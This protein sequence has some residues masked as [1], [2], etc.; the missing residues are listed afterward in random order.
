LNLRC[1]RF[2]HG[3]GHVAAPLLLYL[4]EEETFW[5]LQLLYRRSIRY[6]GSEPEAGLLR[7]VPG[8]DLTSMRMRVFQFERLMATHLPTVC[9]Y[10]PTYLPTSTYSP[11]EPSHLSSQQQHSSN[12]NDWNRYTHG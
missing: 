4:G 3:I 7:Q 10:L 9:T 8:G 2:A 12:V 11:L 5:A 1:D 6:P